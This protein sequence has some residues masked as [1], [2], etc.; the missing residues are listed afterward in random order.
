MT[1]VKF[2]GVNKVYAEDQPEY[3][4][5]PVMAI[6]GPEGEVISCHVL[7][8]EEFE[9]VRTSR[10]IYLHQWTFNGPLQPIRLEVEHKDPIVTME[11]V[12]QMG[13]LSTGL[14]KQK[15]DNEEVKLRVATNYEKQVVTVNFGT[16]IESLAFTRDQAIAI[17]NEMMNRAFTLTASKKDEG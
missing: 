2:P 6:P 14:M 12:E 4:P 16:Q 17:A 9:I 7:S 13:K 10:C 8:A 11:E 3:T 5:L 1:P 15:P